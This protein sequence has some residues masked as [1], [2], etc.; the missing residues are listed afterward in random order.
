MNSSLIRTEA[1]RLMGPQLGALILVLLVYGVLMSIASSVMG[2]GQL[3]VLGPLSLGLAKVLLNILAEQKIS[4]EMLFTGFQDFTRSLIAGLL[5]SIYVFLWSL[6]LIVPGIIASFSYSMTFFIMEENPQMPA[7]EAISASK[8][9]MYGHKWRLFELWFS[10]IG[11][12]LL[13]IITLGI[14]F[15][16]VIPYYSTAT[17][18]FYADLKQ[19]QTNPVM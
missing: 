3:L 9:M 2:I 6:L 13:S 14:A 12:W 15:I 10:F 19:R 11:W 17:A 8:T 16:Y 7:Q 1:R 18:V 4:V 5:V